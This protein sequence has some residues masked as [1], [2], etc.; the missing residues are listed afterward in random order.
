M[1]A[2][3]DF[4]V[5]SVAW[6]HRETLRALGGPVPSI[7]EAAGT[8]AKCRWRGGGFGRRLAFRTQQVSRLPLGVCA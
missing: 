6:D 7:P 8:V 3:P 1:S 4:P 2:V 5:F